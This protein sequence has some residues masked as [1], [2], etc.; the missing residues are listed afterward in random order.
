VV[1]WKKKLVVY[2]ANKFISQG[3]ETFREHQQLKR[4]FV[5][6]AGTQLSPFVSARILFTKVVQPHFGED[7]AQQLNILHPPQ[8]DSDEF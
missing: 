3:D 4:K 7:V 1:G 2:Q 5:R 6:A 8:R